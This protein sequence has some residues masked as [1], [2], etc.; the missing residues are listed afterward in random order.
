MLVVEDFISAISCVVSP[1]EVLPLTFAA[2]LIVCV[3]S[4]SKLFHE[5]DLFIATIKDRN[6]FFSVDLFSN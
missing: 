3:P 2:F 5:K 6:C 1:F 4:Q